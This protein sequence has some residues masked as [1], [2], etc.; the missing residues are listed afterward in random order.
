MTTP[1]FPESDIGF[2]KWV[3][4]YYIYPVG[5]TIK[6]AMPAG[7][8]CMDQTCAFATVKGAQALEA[9]GLPRKEAEILGL[10]AA[11]DGVLLK[12]LCR[13]DPAGAKVLR[14]LEKKD[15]V[16]VTAV[17]QKQTAGIKTEKFICL[18][19]QTPTRR[20]RMSAKREKILAIVREAKEISL[21]TL[22]QHVPTAATLIKPMAEAGWLKVISRRVFRDPLGDPVTP[23][24]APELNR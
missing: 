2:F 14:R 17:L 23:D 8:D 3:A 7:L 12:S 9:G 10:A 24:T 6:A 13:R 15:L 16:Q 18:P 20:I 21:T 11:K 22:K 4:G 1:L 19:D 5:E